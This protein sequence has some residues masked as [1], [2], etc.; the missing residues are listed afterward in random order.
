MKLWLSSPCF[1]LTVYHLD[2]ISHNNPSRTNSKY[3]LFHVFPPL[4][5]L[6]VSVLY[7]FFDLPL[8]NVVS[9]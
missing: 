4:R 6:P 1:C 7:S 3:F 8:S 5:S 9:P 2:F